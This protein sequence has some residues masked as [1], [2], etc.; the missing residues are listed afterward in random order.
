MKQKQINS[1]SSAKGAAQLIIGGIAEL[2]AA[3]TLHYTSQADMNTELVNL[4]MACGDHEQGKQIKA[5][6]RQALI[7]SINEAQ[8]LI[9][10]VRDVVKMTFGNDYSALWTA[11]GFK[12]NSLGVPDSPEDIQDMLDAIYSHLTN[13]PSLEMGTVVT[14]ARAK[15]L[16]DALV[17]A[18][19]AV[20]SQEATI[21]ALMEV[22]DEKY[23]ILRKRISNVYQELRMQLTPLDTRWAKFG[24]VKP[25]ADETPDLVTGVKVTLIGPTAA[26][27]KWEAS[28]RAQYYRVWIRVLG[29][30]AEYRAI[31]SPADLDF[32]I[33]N[34]PAGATIDVIVTAVNN[35]GEGARSE[36]IRVVTH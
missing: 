10:V 3:V 5:T 17:A 28:A 20:T 33:E 13:N 25:G 8:K 7:D 24:F 26:A 27:V 22:R 31:G 29:V 12:N 36:A 30:D 18:Q 32:T 15:V 4:I 19:V 14:A 34:L 2:G 9:R 21:D 23:E 35:G 16:H 11:L 1:I 6:R